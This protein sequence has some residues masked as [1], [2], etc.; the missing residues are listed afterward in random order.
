MIVGSTQREVV[1][2]EPKKL[3]EEEE[4]EVRPPSSQKH[5]R[6]PDSSSEEEVPKKKKVFGFGC[7][8]TDEECEF[9][10]SQPTQQ[11]ESKEIKVEVHSSS[12]AVVSHAPI[13]P[14]S[15]TIVIEDDTE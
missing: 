14:D 5:R 13:T 2:I 11:A 10:P 1:K 3:P 4:E 8:P 7:E 12:P 9:R 15:S 6:L